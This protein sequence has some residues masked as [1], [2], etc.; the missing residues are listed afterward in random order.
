MAQMNSLNF[1]DG[2]KTLMINNDETRTIR[3]NPTDRNIVTRYCETVKKVEELSQKYNSM[4]KE[5]VSTEKFAEIEKKLD[6]EARDLVDFIVG[7]KVADI[8]FDVVNCLSLAGG[9][10][11]LENFLTAYINYMKPSIKAEYEKARKRVKK[12]TNQ[13][14]GFK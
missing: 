14:K 10:S 2:Y 7:S 6:R 5:G 12:Y 9:T 3:I 11:I 1:D 13:A 8:A 4:E